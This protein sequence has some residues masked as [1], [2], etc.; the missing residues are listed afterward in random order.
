MYTGSRNEKANR[1]IHLHGTKAIVAVWLDGLFGVVGSLSVAECREPI[2]NPSSSP[3]FQHNNYETI[4]QEQH[5]VRRMKRPCTTQSSFQ[6]PPKLYVAYC[7]QKE[8][9]ILGIRMHIMLLTLNTCKHF[10]VGEDSNWYQHPYYFELSN[11]QS[12]YPACR[13]ATE[14]FQVHTL[15]KAHLYRSDHWR[16]IFPVC[17]VNFG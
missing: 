8:A 10:S 11:S 6:A 7:A 3:E 16:K 17:M 4:L 13:R 14:I 1:V 12:T 15:T 9:G 2:G 5:A